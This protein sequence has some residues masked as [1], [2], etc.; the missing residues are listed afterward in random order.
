KL[1]KDKPA[2][3]LMF[4]KFSPDGNTVAY[5]SNYN[6]YVE[7]L[8]TQKIIAITTNGNRQLIN[9]TFD[10]AYEEEFFCRDGFRWSPDGKRIAY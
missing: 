7:N 5:V 10:W 1:G 8:A 2:S 6:I 3:S 9:G 4:A